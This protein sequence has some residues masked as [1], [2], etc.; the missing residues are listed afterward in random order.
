MALKKDFPTR[1]GAAIKAGYWK[2]ASV[3]EDFTAGT[4]QIILAGYATAEDRLASAQPLARQEAVLQ[5]T[6]YAPDKTRAEL[7]AV[8]KTTDVWADA[9][10]C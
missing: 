9:E 7:Y 1:Y 2:I 10:D 8:L 6:A 3:V 5:E 4:A